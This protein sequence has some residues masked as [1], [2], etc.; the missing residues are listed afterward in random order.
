MNET[1][2]KNGGV[3]EYI[4]L[5]LELVLSYMHWVKLLNVPI[6][7]FCRVSP[8]VVS[9]L[10][11]QFLQRGF[12]N[13]LDMFP[14]ATTLN[15]AQNS[16]RFQSKSIWVQTEI[17]LS[18]FLNDVRLIHSSTRLLTSGFSSRISQHEMIMIYQRISS[19]H[20]QAILFASAPDTTPSNRRIDYEDGQD[21]LWSMNYLAPGKSSI[22]A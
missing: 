4:K 13:L 3:L 6:I 17:N 14:N 21:N 19:L 20:V 7:T 11:F 10:H 22:T 16:H 18:V 2:Q 1:T 9:R 8:C 15:Q 5:E 12:G